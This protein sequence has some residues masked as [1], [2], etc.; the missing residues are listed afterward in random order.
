MDNNC[1]VVGN[2]ART[3]CA[4]LHGISELALYQEDHPRAT[5]LDSRSSRSVVS[6]QMSQGLMFFRREILRS[7][8]P[9][10]HYCVFT[11]RGV[12]QIGSW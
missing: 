10:Y 6:Q 2:T 11:S 9:K 3:S 12:A 8:R 5:P 1:L 4:L 7:K